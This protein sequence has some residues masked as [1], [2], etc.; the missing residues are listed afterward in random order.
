MLVIHI[1]CLFRHD[2]NNIFA[3]GLRVGGGGDPTAEDRQHRDVE[4]HSA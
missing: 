2:I 1:C 3:E 4:C